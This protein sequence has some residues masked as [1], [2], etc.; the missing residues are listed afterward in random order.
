MPRDQP[1]LSWKRDAEVASPGPEGLDSKPYFVTQEFIMKVNQVLAISALALAAGA[2]LAD[3]APGAPLTRAEVVQSVLD[4][5]A[6]GTLRHAGETAPEEMTPYKK[7]IE[8]RSTLTRAQEK[9]TVLQARADGTLIP[10]GPASPLDDFKAAYAPRSTSTLTRAE[11]K[12]EVLQARADGTLIPAGQ[13]EYSQTDG[14]THY[15]RAVKS[16]SQIFASRSAN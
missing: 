12:S 7:E 13:G 16:P 15:A 4:A 5:R 6:N 9:A 14:A 1:A 11:V 3:E 2:A 8:A 10:A